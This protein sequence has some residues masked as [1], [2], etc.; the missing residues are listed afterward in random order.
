MNSLISVWNEF[1]LIW[2]QRWF[3]LLI[4]PHSEKGFAQ[5]WKDNAQKRTYL[6]VTEIHNTKIIK[7]HLTVRKFIEKYMKQLI[8][9]QD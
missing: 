5:R 9:Y 7:K 1:Y 2:Q 8:N 6:M 4:I 3:K